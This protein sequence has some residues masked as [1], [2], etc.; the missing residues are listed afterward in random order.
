MLWFSKDKKIQLDLVLI[1]KNIATYS[2]KHFELCKANKTHSA[3]AYE[4]QQ[5]YHL[6]SAM[7]AAVKAKSC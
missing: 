2:K 3:A 7:R 5:L 6:W 1:D 4:A